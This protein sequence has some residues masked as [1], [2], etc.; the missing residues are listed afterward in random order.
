LNI[1]FMV[2]SLYLGGI[3]R[4]LSDVSCGLPEDIRQTFVL[5]ENKVAYPH[6]GRV[7]LLHGSL[8]RSMPVRIFNLVR[9]AWRFRRILQQVKPDVVLPLNHDVRNINL[10][11]GMFLPRL[12]YKTIVVD[13]GLSSHYTEYLGGL[14][15]RIYR[16]MVSLALKRTHRIVAIAEGVRADL[17]AGFSVNPD[18]IDII[19][20]SVDPDQIRQMALEPVEHPWFSEQVPIISLTGRLVHGKNQTD[21]LKA[22]AVLRKKTRCRLVFIGDGMDRPALARL[23]H[24]LGIAE[25]V[26]FAGYQTNPHKFVA[27]STVFAFPSM[28]EAQGLVMLEALAVGCPVVACDCP[29]GPREMLAPGTIRAAGPWEMEECRYGLLVPTGNVDALAKAILKLLG[30]SRLRDHYSRIGRERAAQFNPRHMAEQY[31]KSIRT[32]AGVPRQN[33]G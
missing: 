23:S 16:R 17:M 1:L 14:S 7:F 11:A 28:F 5:L 27:R 31:L 3:G 12:Q 33:N 29:C 19:Y 18:K 2:N 13:L 21:L 6:R 24:E 15:Q 30:N 26:L 4:I 25:D 22:F 32:V 8:S 9:N 20:G 10:L